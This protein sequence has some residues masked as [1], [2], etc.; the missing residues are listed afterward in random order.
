MTGWGVGCIMWL[1]VVEK[2]EKCRKVG[3]LR[4]SQSRLHRPRGPERASFHLPHSC[5]AELLWAAEKLPF[6]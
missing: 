4:P 3:I 5:R 6:N 1:K 2:C